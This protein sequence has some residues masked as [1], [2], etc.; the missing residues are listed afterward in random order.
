MKSNIVFC[1]IGGQY[2]TIG[3]K[4]TSANVLIINLLT[5]ATRDRIV[6]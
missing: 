1:G 5:G 3:A 2:L 4:K 6:G